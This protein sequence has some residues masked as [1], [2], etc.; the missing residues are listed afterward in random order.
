[1]G[2]LNFLRL[3]VYLLGELRQRV[4]A[5]QDEVVGVVRVVNGGDGVQYRAAQHRTVALDEHRLQDEESVDVSHAC[6]CARN[7]TQ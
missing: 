2:Y 1:M 4:L 6:T 7:K 3:V 5:L